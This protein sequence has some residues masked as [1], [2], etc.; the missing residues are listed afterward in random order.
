MAT[1]TATNGD[2]DDGGTL[3]FLPRRNGNIRDRRTHCTR[4]VRLVTVTRYY[5]IFVR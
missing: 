2:N 3:F 1:F 4:V 5:G